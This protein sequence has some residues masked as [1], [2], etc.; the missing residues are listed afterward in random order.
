M[1][2][3]YYS[4][5]ATANFG[6]GVPLSVPK[7]AHAPSIG[8]FVYNDVSS[9]GPPHNGYRDNQL[10]ATVNDNEITLL[11][12]G[13]SRRVGEEED[14]II[15]AY[16]GI[17]N[18]IKVAT[19]NTVRLIRGQPEVEGLIFSSIARPVQETVNAQ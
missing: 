6:P 16:G 17:E 7:V 19:E 4:Q 1:G 12:N 9:E 11:T 15:A 5:T 18:T 8:L 2:Y 3:Y 13:K 14:T 10:V